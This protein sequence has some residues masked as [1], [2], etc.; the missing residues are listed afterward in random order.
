M[1]LSLED[2]KNVTNSRLDAYDKAMQE[3]IEAVNEQYLQCDSHL[4]SFRGELSN[5]KDLLGDL[6]KRMSEFNEWTLP[7]N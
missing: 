1:S 4:I 3:K 2:M 7:E 6:T 5:I